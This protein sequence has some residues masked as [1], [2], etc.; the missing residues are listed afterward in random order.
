LAGTY[1]GTVVIYTFLPT[2]TY[3]KSALKHF[4]STLLEPLTSALNRNVTQRTL[5]QSMFNSKTTYHLGLKER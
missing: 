1:I 5:I 2:H 3:I 4:G